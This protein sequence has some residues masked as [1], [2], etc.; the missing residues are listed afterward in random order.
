MSQGTRGQLGRAHARGNEPEEGDLPPLP[1]M[2]QVLIEVERN[3]R[4]SH[5][6]LGVIDRNT[7]QQQNEL[8][9]L[10]D[11]INLHPPLFSYS[12]EPLDANDWLRSI[13]RKLQV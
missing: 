5:D 2:A 7:A 10:N 4:D 8:V 11:F 3:Q 13:E 12:I 9:S 6:L 1:T